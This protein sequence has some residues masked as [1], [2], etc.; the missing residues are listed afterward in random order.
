[1]TFPATEIVR[2]SR[3]SPKWLLPARDQHPRQREMSGCQSRGQVKAAVCGILNVVRA[4][5]SSRGPVRSRLARVNRRRSPRVHCLPYPIPPQSCRSRRWQS[6]LLVPADRGPQIRARM[7]S[8][9]GGGVA[10]D[11]KEGTSS[12]GRRPARGQR[13]AGGELGC[14][15]AGAPPRDGPSQGDLAQ[16]SAA[17]L[18]TARDQQC[19]DFSSPW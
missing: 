19:A 13:D 3:S 8:R 4:A 15:Y 18:P 17:G 5:R 12:R 10:R 2:P 14:W 9:G 7:A 1:M 11:A 6:C 16:R